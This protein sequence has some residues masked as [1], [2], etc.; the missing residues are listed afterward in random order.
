MQKCCIVVQNKV[1]CRCAAKLVINSVL[2]N[3]LNLV[4]KRVV[5]HYYHFAFNLSSVSVQIVQCA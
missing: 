4:L 5:T 2:L 3:V 1:L